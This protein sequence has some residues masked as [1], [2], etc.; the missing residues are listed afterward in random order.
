MGSTPWLRDY[1]EAITLDTRDS[2]QTA[3]LDLCLSTTSTGIP[4]D[5]TRVCFAG[6]KGVEVSIQLLG[7]PP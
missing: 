5:H 3:G 7:F 1:S 4:I 6:L 2:E